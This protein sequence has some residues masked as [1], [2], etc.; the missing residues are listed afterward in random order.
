MPRTYEY[1]PKAQSLVYPT[2][3]LGAKDFF[4]GWTPEQFGKLSAVCA[5]LC[6]LVYGPPDFVEKVLLAA[7]KGLGLGNVEWIGGES[8][9]ARA[10]SFG[11]DGFVAERDGTLYVV[12][13]GTQLN[14]FEDLVTDLMSI[15]EKDCGAGRVHAGFTKTFERTE[16]KDHLRNLLANRSG[17]VV[18]T[19]HSLGGA[20]ATLA[21]ASFGKAG[22]PLITFGSPRVGDPVF[23]A[24]LKRKGL[25]IDRYVL[26]CD[27]IARLPPKRLPTNHP[28]DL[29]T[30]V[31]GHNPVTNG[32]DKLLTKVA[33]MLAGGSSYE[34][35]GEIHY[36]DREGTLHQEDWGW[37]RIHADQEAARARYAE[38]YGSKLPL[39][40]GKLKDASSTLVRLALAKLCDGTLPSRDTA[41]HN[42]KNY[43]GPLLN[44]ASAGPAPK[45]P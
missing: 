7:K 1:D 35:I 13:R 39:K 11:A 6:R 21:A 23:A 27:I 22:D 33:N 44:K 32:I 34:H 2:K 20:M 17:K 4:G 30:A 16:V 28:E 10:G 45:Q 5:E 24:E 31:Y 41:D 40:L 14:R 19:G 42:L 15:S 29:L 18:F 26:C 9:E 3:D 25:K 38:Q 12:F 43:L 37:D 36:I 8:A